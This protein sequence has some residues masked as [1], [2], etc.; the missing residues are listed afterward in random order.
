M[1]LSIWYA[2]YV[3]CR[4][5]VLYLV[6]RKL[7]EVVSWFAVQLP[8]LRKFRG[9]SWSLPYEEKVPLLVENY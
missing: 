1:L 9:S 2:I 6:I 4:K 7:D 3:R 8:S 5:H